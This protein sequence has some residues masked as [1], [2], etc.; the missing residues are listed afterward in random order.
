MQK[1]MQNISAF[2]PETFPTDQTI[3][4]NQFKMFPINSNQNGLKNQTNDM[5]MV[6]SLKCYLAH[7]SMPFKLATST[8]TKVV[9]SVKLSGL[10]KKI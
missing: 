7:G 6:V 9:I 5:D 10:T 3:S 1:L 2:L 4:T 8:K